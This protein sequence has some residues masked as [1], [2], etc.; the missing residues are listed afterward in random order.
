M[1][2][3]GRLCGGGGGWCLGGLVVVAMFFY[4]TNSQKSFSL[5]G[6]IFSNLLYQLS[7]RAASNPSSARASQLRSAAR[8]PGQLRTA[9]SAQL[10][11]PAFAARWQLIPP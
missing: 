2:L 5:G 8:P 4:I 7:G 10:I 9:A 11:V 6:T 1:D 3:G